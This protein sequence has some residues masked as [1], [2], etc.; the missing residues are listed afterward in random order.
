[1]TA[2]MSRAR[3]N[4][5]PVELRAKG[6]RGSDRREIECARLRDGSNR[7]GMAYADARFA[8][9]HE[10]A[11]LSG[12]PGLLRAEPNASELRSGVLART[13]DARSGVLARTSDPRSGVLARASDALS[14]VLARP[15]SRA[16]GAAPPPRL[17][18]NCW[19]CVL[20]LT[21]RRSID[22]VEPREAV[23]APRLSSAGDDFGSSSAVERC[24]PG[25]LLY[26]SDAADDM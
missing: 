3:F 18:I 23:D 14:G 21:R 12:V 9:R 20:R 22:A 19:N 25:C 4:H 8:M 7:G 11:E 1:M 24:S 5:S 2:E 15:S 6:S 26:T 16:S 17:A 13:S 10:R